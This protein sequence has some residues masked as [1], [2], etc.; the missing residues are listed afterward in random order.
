[1]KNIE[2]GKVSRLNELPVYSPPGHSGTTNRRLVLAEEARDF[3]MV[4]GCI[5]PGGEAEEHNHPDSYQAIYVLSGAAQVRLNGT[6][7]YRCQAG[8]TI[9]IPKGIDHFV[10]SVGETS[11][12]MIIVY[13]PPISR[14]GA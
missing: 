4:H 9:N 11:L 2:L 13:S 8:D 5:A 6:D 12:E 1:M 7:D 14:Q 10:K 3:E